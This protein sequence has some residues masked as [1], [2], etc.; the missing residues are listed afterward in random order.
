MATYMLKIICVIILLSISA[1]SQI[2][3]SD[4]IVNQFGNHKYLK[5]KKE[6]AL[7]KSLDNANLIIE[8]DTFHVQYTKD[9]YSIWKS[10]PVT[11]NYRMPILDADNNGKLECYGVS[12]NNNDTTFA[13]VYEINKV[14]KLLYKYDGPFRCFWDEGSIKGD[15][16]KSIVGSG[17][18]NKMVFFKQSSPNSLLTEPDFVFNPNEQQQQPDNL[19]FYDIDGDGIQEL[20]YYFVA[21][22]MDSV[23]AYANNIAKYNPL[24]N[25]YEIVYYNRPQ[26]DFYTFGIVTGDFDND[27]KGNFATGSIDGKMYVY[28][29]VSGNNYKVE[30]QK[31]MVCNNLYLQGFSHDMDG[32]GKPELW[33]G[34][35]FNSLTYGG[36]TR[37]FAFEPTGDDSYQQVYQI[38]IRGLFALSIGDIRV[39]D[40]DNDGKEE[41]MV[42]NGNY[43]FFFKCRGLR[44]YY[45]DFIYL[46][47]MADSSNVSQW[48]T[49]AMDLDKDGI[50][51]LLSFNTV[52]DHSR[53]STLI[54]KR[55]LISGISNDK[56]YL[57]NDFKLYQNYPNP[58][59]GMTRIKYSVPKQSNVCI[60]IRDLLGRAIKT[61]IS[62]SRNSGVYETVWDG[63]DDNHCSVS[64]GV[65]F[66]SMVSSGYN[67]SIKIILLK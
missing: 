22:S 26:P 29:Y 10:L 16:I 59:N 12:T 30:F 54:L 38:D 56:E 51:E 9:K 33:I 64:S 50:P 43:M 11:S 39:A 24:T 1:Y 17:N 28:E 3:T 55:N 67:K 31:Q 58:F 7:N 65:Y 40:F 57:P 4:I 52:G 62:D 47:P 35:D 13:Y 44:D 66:I 53:G 60:I 15:G 6:M 23:W 61:L 5:T 41:V 20:I 19:T 32:N 36:I 34:G 46:D 49:D 25:N 27:G 21:G 2:D 8:L 14:P 42:R 37:I 45:C 48:G 63:T 18:Y